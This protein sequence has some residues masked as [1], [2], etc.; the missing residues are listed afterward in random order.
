MWR[1]DRPNVV[2]AKPPKLLTACCGAVGYLVHNNPRMG[3]AVK[4][5]GGVGHLSTCVRA[6][7][8]H[9]PRPE[10]PRGAPQAGASDQ[11]RSLL[12]QAEFALGAVLGCA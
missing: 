4:D 11:W 12:T 8:L 2:H 9:A 7:T 5:C 6:A 10:E 3:V 1:V